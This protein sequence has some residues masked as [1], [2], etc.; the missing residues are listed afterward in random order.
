MTERCKNGF[1]W[2]ASLGCFGACFTRCSLVPQLVVP[3]PCNVSYEKGYPKV[4]K[5]HCTSSMAQVDL[6][7][8]PT[9][10]AICIWILQFPCWSQLQ[11]VKN[12]VVA[13]GSQGGRSAP[14][15]F[16]T[17][18]PRPLIPS[19]LRLSQPRLHWLR[20][21]FTQGTTGTCPQEEGGVIHQ[22]FKLQDHALLPKFQW[23]ISG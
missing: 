15:E 7:S 10:T 12:P 6:S 11:L 4:S 5:G 2:L 3:K 21:F 13:G 16:P 17:R 9:S 20:P 1:V 19:H 18:T 8:A 23:L 22:I 14:Q